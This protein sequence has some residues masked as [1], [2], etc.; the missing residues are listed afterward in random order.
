M[1]QLK[2][3]KRKQAD[4]R[5]AGRSLRINVT[6]ADIK[7]GKRLNPN[8]C[9]AAQCILRATKADAVQVNRGVTYIKRGKIWTRYAT[10]GALRLETIV[11]DRGGRFIPG[12]YDLSPVPLGM[13][14]RTSKPRSPSK[15]MTPRESKLATRRMVIPGVRQR[16]QPSKLNEE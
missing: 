9:A 4:V 11:W 16:A 5:N 14:V 1:K 7:K 13:I 8:A 2:K 6:E 10:T 12:E 15:G 3:Q